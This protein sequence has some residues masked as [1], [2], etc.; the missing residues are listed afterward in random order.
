[1][2]RDL[3]PEPAAWTIE[4]PVLHANQNGSPGLFAFSAHKRVYI[5][6]ITVTSNEK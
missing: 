5:D 6:N 2:E 4:V 3:A 1:M